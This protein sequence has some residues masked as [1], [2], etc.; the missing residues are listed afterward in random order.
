MKA[1]PR[2]HL[3]G[4]LLLAFLVRG[5]V[6]VW[7]PDVLVA[8]PDAYRGYSENLVEHGVYG[9]GQVPSAFRPPLYPLLLTPA[10]SAG[11]WARAAIGIVHLVLGVGTVWLVYRL[12]VRWDLGRW[13]ALAA[14]LVACD[15]ILL[16]QST[17]VMTETLATLLAVVSLLA[18]TAAADDRQL[19]TLRVAVAGAC[20]GLAALCRPTF[21]VFAAFAEL[22]L[23]ARA[24]GWSAR[25]KTFGC[26]A[27]AAA[28]VLV[29]WIV[30][31]QVSMGR[32][33]VATTHGGYTLLLSNNPSFYDY[34][35]QRSLGTVWE[36]DDYFDD[37]FDRLP[38]GTPEAELEANRVA[39]ADARRHIAQQ[40]GMFAYSCVVRIGRLWAPLPHQIGD[41][42]SAARRLMRYGVGLWY[43]V[44]F[45]F[46]AIG[47]LAVFANGRRGSETGL[48]AVRPWVWGLLLAG[49][50]TLV[51]AVFWSNM[52][53]RAPIVPVVALAATAGVASIWGRARER[54]ALSDNDLSV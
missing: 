17:L 21:L 54:K 11:D 35:R 29:P 47:L 43:V 49:S 32:P 31:N 24:E 42:E 16:Q 2:H 1:Q 4:L 34:L 18:L 20:L 13:S 12:A 9:H 8:D 48:F 14:A 6:L 30:R 28:L 25:L 33:I 3:L 41:H 52:R 45:S 50:F 46:A 39:Y 22:V 36:K 15:P 27:I 23:A 37:W 19:C 10:V 7:M 26:F 38:R 40:P 5:G 44:L 51:H 53:M